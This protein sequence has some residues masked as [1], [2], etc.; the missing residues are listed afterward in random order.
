MKR[1]YD[2]DTVNRL[3]GSVPLSGLIIAFCCL[4][5]A[6][7]MVGCTAVEIVDVNCNVNQNWPSCNVRGKKVE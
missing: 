2:E 6:V 5:F 7:I 3:R 1:D 4:F